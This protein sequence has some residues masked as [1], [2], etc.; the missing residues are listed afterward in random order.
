M[1]QV[2][3]FTR[4]KDWLGLGRIVPLIQ[5]NGY[6][7]IK[8][9]N[10]IEV[11]AHINSFN[12][13]SLKSLCNAHKIL[14]EGL[15]DS[16]GKLRGKSVDIIQGSK[17]THVAPPGEMIKPLMHD[18]FKY[19]ESNPDL[20]LIKSCVFHY[21]LEFI[22]PFMDGNGRIGRLWQTLILKQQYPVFEFLPIESLIKEKQADYYSA[23]N[24]SDKAGNS[25]QFIEFMLDV[26]DES[27]ESLLQT[28]SFLIKLWHN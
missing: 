3:I 17:I 11:Y 13:Y 1:R 28:V 10:A 26:I 19:L 8:V 7:I 21:E 25:T 12:P 18:L 23:L 9:K 5:E 27:L 6:Q 14:M 2:T 20:D 15:V 24:K 22:H 4:D 16:P